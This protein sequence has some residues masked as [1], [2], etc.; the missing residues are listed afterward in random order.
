MIPEPA[1]RSRP[2][3]E[4]LLAGGRLL[5]L[6]TGETLETNVLIGGGVILGIGDYREA[7]HVYDL[8]GAIM[9]PGFIDGHVHIESSLLTPPRFAEAVVPRGT[10]TVVA[11]PH[12]IANVLG[13]DGVRW[14]LRATASLPLDVFLMAPPCVPA[15]PLDTAGA[16]LDSDAVR[17]ML[18]WDRVI[19]LGEVMDVRGVI[20]A[21]PELGRK[22][23]HARRFRRP[24]DGHAPGLSGEPLN[25]YLAAGIESDHE[26]RALGEAREKL[27]L[28][29][30]IMIRQG[31]QA[32]NLRD[33]APIVDAISVRHCL[34]VSDDRN[35]T[36]LVHEGHLDHA[37]REAVA[38]GVPPLWAIQ[39]VTLNAAEHFGLRHLGAL[40]PGRQAD[41]VVVNDLQRFRP[42]LVFK[43]GRLVAEHGR[44][45]E[46]GSPAPPVSRTMN[47]A[48]LSADA[49]RIPHAAAMVRVIALVPGQLVTEEIVMTPTTRNGEVVSDPA[50]DLAKIVV[51][52]RHHASGRVG[53]GLVQGFG[54]SHGALASSVAHDSHHLVAVGT[55]DADL[56]AALRHVIRDGGGLAV[57]SHGHVRASLGLPVA[58]LMTDRPA[59]DAA[60]ALA[61]L[62]AEARRLGVTLAHPFGA[63][64]FLALPVIPKLRLTDHGL[65]DSSEGRLVPLGVDA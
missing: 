36:D 21:E 16:R 6:F 33:L 12:E 32:R 61:E 7:P 44:V 41:V 34:L 56:F 20:A 13:L 54:L 23:D 55:S 25:D 5:N 35:A 64:S 58:G 17:Q 31:S 22:I 30:R 9:L 8:D 42:E 62:E 47:V 28:G 18:A 26:C 43:R 49:L 29:T 51:V 14:M 37:L 48:P 19:G 2:D 1:R 65:V 60:R 59:H 11:D 46:P 39:M 63:L 40:A 45:C 4:T 52:E 53:R 27:R 10:T 50:R 3:A 24:V 15:S 57:A 38:L